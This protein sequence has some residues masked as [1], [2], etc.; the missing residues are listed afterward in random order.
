M[1]ENKEAFTL[2]YE[3]FFLQSPTYAS[4]KYDDEKMY[5]AWRMGYELGMAFGAGLLE[6][7]KETNA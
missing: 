7:E 3:R 6:K 1:I 4:L 2:W 5:I